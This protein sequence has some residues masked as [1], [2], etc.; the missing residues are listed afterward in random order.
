[1]ATYAATRPPQNGDRVASHVPRHPAAC[2]YQVTQSQTPAPVLGISRHL[3][4]FSVKH[5]RCRH[6]TVWPHMLLLGHHKMVIEWHLMSHV[7]P[8][9]S[10]SVIVKLYFILQTKKLAGTRTRRPSTRSEGRKAIALSRLLQCTVPHC[11]SEPMN[12]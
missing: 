6:G 3:A 8:S 12:Q 4:G 5:R 11:N 9:R 2:C 10:R 7:T 1:M